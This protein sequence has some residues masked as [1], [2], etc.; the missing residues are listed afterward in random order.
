MADSYRLTVQKRLAELL[1]DIVPVLGKHD[2]T[3]A[4]AV[5]RGRAQFGDGDPLPMLSLLEPPRPSDASAYAGTN[6]D[7]RSERW[8]LILQGW[9]R[10]DLANP[11]DGAY[12]LMAA[13]EL[14]LGKVKLTDRYGDPID[15][16]WYML[17]PGD[18][19]VGGARN[20]L[21]SSFEFGPGVVSPPR[22]QVSTQA[23]FFMPIWIGLAETAGQ[24]YLAG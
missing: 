14:Q 10:N 9:V 19:L 23:F 6:R 15:A 8:P 5:F 21:I 4:G 11:S 1:G 24:P 18:A 2:F 17:G 16:N 20:R 3:L 22:E 12:D 7:T 13:V